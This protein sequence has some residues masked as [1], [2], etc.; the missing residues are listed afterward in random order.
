MALTT[1]YRHWRMFGRFSIP[2][3]IN[4]FLS[5]QL[6]P[7]VL[8]IMQGYYQISSFNVPREPVAQ[9]VGNCAVVDYILI[10]RRSR[11]RAGLRYQRRGVD[12]GAHVANFVETE[13]IMRVEVSGIEH[14]RRYV[15]CSLSGLKR[16]GYSNV[17]SY[18]QIRG[19]S[20]SAFAFSQA[21]VNFMFQ[22]LCSGRS[23][24][25]D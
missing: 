23:L 11:E 14:R 17:F 16:E 6:H 21:K 7:Y 10:S 20:K 19:S 4:L 18:V 24:A 8:P 13:T 3:G 2:V 25:T 9:E 5:H 15:E 22:Y 1:I 12:D